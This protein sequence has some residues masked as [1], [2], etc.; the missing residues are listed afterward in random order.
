MLRRLGVDT[1]LR[2]GV[3]RARTS[4]VDAHAWIECGEEVVV[5]AI[6]G[7]DDYSPLSPANGHGATRIN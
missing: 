1:A 5:G 3:S 7:L 6:D 2:I 4:P